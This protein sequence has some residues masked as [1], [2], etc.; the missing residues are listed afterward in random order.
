M[1]RLITVDTTRR[2]YKRECF[3]L[4]IALVALSLS[5]FAAK[6][7]NA[8][9]RTAD[10]HCASLATADFSGEMDVTVHVTSAGWVASRGEI[11]GYCRVRGQVTPVFDLEVRL[12]QRWNGKLLAIGSVYTSADECDPFVSRG[13]ACIP[14][15]RGGREGR[16]D[17]ELLAL[18]DPGL[19]VDLAIRSP[20]LLTL[21]G[22]A[23]ATRYYTAE[24]KQSYFMGCSS[25][26]YQAMLEAQ[27]FPW[28]YDGI[29][30]GAPNLDTA[31][32]L[33]R[34]AWSARN[35]LD[36]DR[37]PLFANDDLRVLHRAVM[38]Q[39]DSDD[40]LDDGIIGN[41]IG[42]KPDLSRL[43]CSATRTADCLT[44]AQLQ[45]VKR[46]Y[47]GPTTSSG[48]RISSPGVL[49]GSELGWTAFSERGTRLADKHFKFVYH[50]A[51]PALDLR[52][53]EFDR[54]YKRR[55]L[56]SLQAHTNPDLRNF[57]AAGA[58]LIA[59]QGGNDIAQVAGGVVDYYETVERTMGGRQPTQDFFR[60][61]MVP[62]MDHCTGGGGAYAIDYLGY[63]EA[64]VERGRA[65]DAMIGAHIDEQYLMSLPLSE[66][67]PASMRADMTRET[68]LAIAVKSLRFP[69]VPTVPVSFTRPV[70]PYPFYA[71]Y[72]G[73]G[74]PADAA[75]FQPIDPN[76]AAASVSRR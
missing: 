29:V 67:L 68:R 28:D 35:L 22:K 71:R 46:L 17:D 76:E 66:N 48:M 47:A 55:G 70:Y 19:Q 60:L 31:D 33:M 59:Y 6:P 9:Q 10:A 58:K 12:P 4:G 57:K 13:Y 75:N 63:L 40:G 14:M 51:Q 49:P 34:A 50:E 8:S 37:K 3:V 36:D 73:T 41:A 30:A 44:H 32:W 54:D 23:I 26:G 52:N 61:F 21:A 25:G 56:G 11:P 2:A 39:C 45:A 72:R 24:P 74:S 5:C 64:W 65:P 43:A 53:F 69:L 62:G 42:C 15:F 38:K 18:K 27:L 16:S 20:H 1:S 7:L